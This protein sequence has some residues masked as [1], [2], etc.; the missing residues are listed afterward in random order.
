VSTWPE[1]TDRPGH[2]EGV[3]SCVPKVGQF[4]PGRNDYF[5]RKKPTS[6]S[7]TANLLSHIR[8]IVPPKTVYKESLQI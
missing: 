2:A 7:E 4:F 3:M 6:L 1:L 8:F 5:E